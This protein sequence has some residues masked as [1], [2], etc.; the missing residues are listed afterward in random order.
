MNTSQPVAEATATGGPTELPE[1]VTSAAMRN[2]RVLAEGAIAGR[3]AW[4]PD[5]SAIVYTRKTRA[6]NGSLLNDLFSVRISGGAITRLTNGRRASSPAF[7]KDPNR[8]A[9]VG[10]SSGTANIFI[11]DTKTQQETQITRF[12]GDVQIGSIAWHPNGKRIA[13]AV[14]DADGVRRVDLVNLYSGATRSLTDGTYDDRRP[15]WSA[16]GTALAYTS[17]R[18][19]VPNV[20]SCT[21]MPTAHDE[22]TNASTL[23]SGSQL[24]C[25]DHRRV[26]NLI[27]GASATDWLVSRDVISPSATTDTGNEPMRVSGPFLEASVIDSSIARDEPGVIVARVSASKARDLAYSIR[28]DRSPY[29][30]PHDLP[31]AFEGWMS[32]APPRTLPVSIHPDSSLITSRGRYK[33]LRNLTH[34][35]SIVSP[36]ISTARYGIGGL[37]IWSEPLAKHMGYAGLGIDGRDPLR[38]SGLLFG[39]INN[40][41]RPSIETEIKHLPDSPRPYGKEYLLERLSEITVNSIWRLNSDRPFLSRAVSVKVGFIHVDP[42]DFDNLSAIDE[43]LP[44]PETGQQFSLRIAYARKHLRPWVDNL[45][46]PL[47][48]FGLRGRITAAA[49]GFNHDQKYLRLDVSSFRVFPSLWRQRLFVY[50]RA[51]AQFGE[52]LAQDFL[53]LSRYDVFQVSAPTYISFQS[54]NSER[55]RGFRDFVL[56]KAILFGSIEYRIPLTR[57]LDTEL[58]GLVGF[59]STS[60]SFFADGAIVSPSTSFDIV[61]RRLGLGFEL[62]NAITLGGIVTFMHAVGVAQPAADFGTERNWEIY[63]RIRK[64]LP[65]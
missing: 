43:G 33:P 17:L 63:Y 40:T 24:H 59:G 57:S 35:A 53:G 12:T 36:Y 18:D 14:F 45:V 16:D 34:V 62:K 23:D 25:K 15:V 50:G 1:R 3:L 9:F 58:L 32:H 5:G 22:D 7:G 47:D 4:S 31:P 13:Y 42:R 61:E 44:V 46:H 54:S 10:S 51:Q 27:T 60:A 65:F 8:V 2:E 30:R 41:L 21:L 29:Q 39:Y 6:A 55:V 49:Q 56:G 64:T 28:A 26:T 38:E 20:F 11:L 37:T 52:S 19:G 48:G